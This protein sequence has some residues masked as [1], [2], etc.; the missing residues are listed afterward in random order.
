MNYTK[1]NYISLWV[2]IILL[3]FTFPL[4]IISQ[5]ITFADEKTYSNVIDDL[6]L[7]ED[8]SVEDY[9][10]VATDYS[11]KVIQ[12][13]ESSE[14]ELF[15]YTYQPTAQYKNYIATKINMSTEV[16]DSNFNLYDLQLINSNS[17]FYKYL[18]KDFVVNDNDIRNYDIASIYR[19]FDD[20]VDES[21]EEENGNVINQVSFEVAKLYTMTTEN[22]QTQIKCFDTEVINVTDKYVGF[23]RIEDGH[24][25][26]PS[27]GMSWYKPGYDSHFIAFNTDKNIDKLYSATVYYSSQDYFYTKTSTLLVV[28]DER[29]VF[30]PITENSPVK[31][32]YTDSV[33]IKVPNGPFEGRDYSF[34]R[35][36]KVSDFIKTEDREWI[37]E[38]G[39]FNVSVETKLTDK[40]L[41]EIKDKQWIIRFAETEWKDTQTSL[42]STITKTK[43][44]TIVGNVSLLELKF[45]TDGVVYDLGVVD[46]MQTGDGQ[47]DNETN[48]K[49]TIPTWVWLLT[50]LFF[51][52]I[53]IFIFP[54]VIVAI[55][56]LLFALVKFIFNLIKKIFIW[57]INLFKKG[58]KD[59]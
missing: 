30:N 56:K 7:D 44:H 53:F 52:T 27:L 37:Y 54:N 46:N 45:E 32:D 2:I 36:Q 41:S 35:I 59:G 34:E 22:G 43:S 57:I 9:P 40:G 47:P 24:T 25:G 20:M 28:T 55:F 10:V 13:A 16:H 21:I 42:G 15:I 18:V 48:T 3:I 1:N 23:V 14:D 26:S 58:G 51:L 8:F 38:L 50:A 5:Y 39:L 4:T 29:E 33:E 17:V 19:K 12:I 11:I 31:I 49:V 6:E